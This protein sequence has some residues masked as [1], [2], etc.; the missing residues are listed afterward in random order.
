MGHRILLV[1]D[2]GLSRL[3][4][5]SILE[6]LGYQVLGVRDG[7]EAVTAEA[8]GDFQAVVMDCQMPRMDGFQATAEI[9]RR[10]AAEQS[11][12]TPIIGLSGRAMEGDHDAAIA[13]GMDAYLMKPVMVGELRAALEQWT[14]ARPPAR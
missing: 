6:K 12:R 9:R 1:E 2:N 7:C 4:T 14:A 10:E 11:A 5:H 13:K 3:A 8:L